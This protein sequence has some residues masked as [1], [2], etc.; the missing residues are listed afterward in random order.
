MQ[1][2]D[3]NLTK[4]QLKLQREDLD[5][6]DFGAIQTAHLQVQVQADDSFA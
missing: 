3:Q 1:V 6:G 4:K 2:D 5:L